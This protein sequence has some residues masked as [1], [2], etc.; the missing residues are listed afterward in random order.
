MMPIAERRITPSDIIPVAQWEQVRKEKRA[1]LI[2]QKKLRRVEVG[3]FATF[4]FESYDTMLAQVQEM[5]RI[6][7]GG[8]E[9]LADELAAYN[10]L[11]PQGR[12]LVATLM[13]EIDDPVRRLNVLLRL[14]GVEETA[15]FDVG[16]VRV[17]A[18]IEDD[19]DR[20]SEDGKTSSV[21]FVHFPF[22]DELVAKFSD[23]SVQV[24][25]G[26]GHENYAH[27]AVISPAT[28]TALAQDFA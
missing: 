2:A 16:G 15:F 13:F 3:P 9:Q 14:A 18:V 7:K 5:L 20:V 23:P 24:L 12:E 19:A 21:H 28:R 27:L 25:L 17:E 22:T 4:Y 1:A 8:D 11:I 10:P 6:E 26:L